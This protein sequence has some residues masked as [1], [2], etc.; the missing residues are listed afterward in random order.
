[1]TN[2]V[3]VLAFS[4]I[5]LIV[6]AGLV[7]AISLERESYYFMPGNGTSSVKLL[8]LGITVLAASVI[9]I[10]LQLITYRQVKQLYR[11]HPS[12]RQTELFQVKYQPSS[13][14]PMT[15]NLIPIDS[16]C[17]V[18]TTAAAK[19][20]P[21]PV[22]KSRASRADLEA[23]FYY[24]VISIPVL[25][26]N[27]ASGAFIISNHIC[28]YADSTNACHRWETVLLYTRTVQILITAC[29]PLVYFALSSEFRSACRSRF[30]TTRHNKT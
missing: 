13:S 15:K 1:M 11:Q 22:E 3:V 10:V 12:L 5:G 29:N 25:V 16:S 19:Y 4:M 17:A 6:L 7:L 21:A 2:R 8:L 27:G 26:S 24:F 18:I 9:G 30:G 14:R 20:S 23:G 28:S